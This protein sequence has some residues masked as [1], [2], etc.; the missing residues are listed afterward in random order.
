MKNASSSLHENYKQMKKKLLI[1]SI[2]LLVT[3]YVFT[4][5]ET[6][7]EELLR[8]AQIHKEKWDANRIEVLNYS[9][10]NNIPYR[11]QDSIST[12]EM[13]YLDTWGKPEYYQTDRKSVV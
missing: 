4:Q 3:P 7:V 10:L 1:I 2:F 5:T 13:Q 8:L 12:F 11:I 9:D 6:N